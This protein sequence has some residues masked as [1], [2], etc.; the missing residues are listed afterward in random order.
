MHWSTER[1]KRLSLDPGEVRSD[2]A[3]LTYVLVDMTG[4]V[5]GKGPADRLCFYCKSA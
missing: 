5:T 3:E 4:D 1:G 2:G